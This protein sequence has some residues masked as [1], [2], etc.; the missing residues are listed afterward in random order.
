MKTKNVTPFDRRYI[1]LQFIDF[2]RIVSSK[3]ILPEPIR[4]PRI[5]LNIC[6]RVT[7]KLGMYVIWDLANAKYSSTQDGAK[8]LR[9]A[10]EARYR[11]LKYSSAS[12]S[13]GA[14]TRPA[15]LIHLKRDGG[16]LKRYIK[17]FHCSIRLERFSAAY[18]AHIFTGT[19]RP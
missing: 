19:A 4:D 17:Y 10:K 3:N 18:Q 2:G 1:K 8:I 6:K 14:K 11:T 7:D 12:E 5:P 16:K 13:S 9:T 15:E